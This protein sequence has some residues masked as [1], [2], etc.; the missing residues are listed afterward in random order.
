MFLDNWTVPKKDE[1]LHQRVQ[2]KPG[3]DGLHR[4]SLPGNTLTMPVAT[5]SLLRLFS[6]DSVNT[7]STVQGI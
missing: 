1:Q 7:A 5:D 6:E 3:E 2:E 4:A